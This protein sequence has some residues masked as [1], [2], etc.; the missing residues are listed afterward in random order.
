MLSADVPPALWWWAENVL[1]DNGLGKGWRLS[2]ATFVVVVV[3]VAW[4]GIAYQTIKLFS[5]LDCLSFAPKAGTVLI[6]EMKIKTHVRMDYFKLLRKAT[7][8]P[9]IFRLSPSLVSVLIY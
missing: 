6:Y 9:R 8:S 1:E 4:P 7:S 2:S 5:Q 3:V